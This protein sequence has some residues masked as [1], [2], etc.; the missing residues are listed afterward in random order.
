MFAR[1]EY[2]NNAKRQ[3]AAEEHG[4]KEYL[5]GWDIG[6]SSLKAILTDTCGSIAG[7][8]KK[9]VRNLHPFPGAAELDSK[10]VWQSLLSA[11][12]QLL[13]QTEVRPEHIVSLGISTLCPGF[14]LFN[15]SNEILYP[16]VIVLDSR[17]KVE[18]DALNEEFG[19]QAFFK[20]GGNRVIAGGNTLPLLLWFRNRRPD[21][22]RKIAKIGYLSTWIGFELTGEMA[23]D[24]SCASYSGLFDMRET[25]KWAPHLLDAVSVSPSVLPDL[26]YGSDKLG[27]LRNEGLIALGLRRGISVSV[28]GADTACSALAMGVFEDSQQFLSLG[29]S[30]VLCAGASR[31][32]FDDRFMNRCHIT[33]D[34]W[35]MNGAMSNVGLSM[36]WVKSILF[37][38]EE[39]RNRETEIFH[40]MD[41]CAR[42]AVPGAGGTVFLPYLTGERT[43]V[44][45]TSAQGVWFGLRSDTSRSEL[46]RSV[47]ESTGYGLRQIVEIVENLNGAI[48]D[49]IPVIGGGASSSV[50]LQI[51]SDIIG[52]RLYSVNIPDIAGVGA[53]LLGGIADGIYTDGVEAASFIEKKAVHEYIPDLETGDT[54]RKV[55]GRYASL[56][57]LLKQL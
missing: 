43:P 44:W 14:V 25:R 18:A 3:Y 10:E 21:I 37:S 8:V 35:L 2:P 7:S 16:P 4:V 41:E 12:D 50:W 22:Y 47:L 1:K 34:T 56:Y 11:T 17:S 29:T 57:P 30:G 24:Y 45:D 23:L 31:S 20:V 53:A 36:T 26:G 54:Y 51:I 6:T 38:E 40:H 9:T 46:I 33:G 55:F 49:D 39:Q 28:G 13:K 27:E 15:S 5:L 52:K 42:D 32:R 48:D 19:P